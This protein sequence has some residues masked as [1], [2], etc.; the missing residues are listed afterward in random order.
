MRTRSFVLFLFFVLTSV[1]AFAQDGGIR[2]S[3]LEK[4]TRQPVMLAYVNVYDGNNKSMQTTVQTDEMG[5]AVV[6]PERYPCTIEVVSLGFEPF[7]Q[8]FHRQPLSGA[9]A[10]ILTKKFGSINEVVV[11]GNT[12]PMR[13]KDALSSYQVISRAQIQAMGAVTLN[14]A[15]KN[16][17]NIQISNDNILGS[18]MQLQGMSG[19]KVKILKDGVPL[20]GREGG[21]INLSQINLNNVERIEI[22][23]GPMSVTY[24]TDAL[25]GV[26]NI[27]TRN[28]NR[29]WGFNVNT[30]YESIGRYNFDVSG[31]YK[32]GNRHQFTLGGGMN[33]FQGW[34]RIYNTVQY[35]QHSLVTDRE[36]LFKPN[37][38][39][40][41]NFAYNY[42]APSGF[43]MQLASDYIGEKVTNKLSPASGDYNP[44][45]IRAIDE[46]YRTTR[47]M[48]RLALN[49]RLGKKGTWQSQNGYNIYYRTRTTLDVDMTDFSDSLSARPGSQDT[50]RFDDITSR[51]SYTNKIDRVTYTVG[52]DV[53]L[54][55]ANSG[56]IPGGDKQIQDY[57]L[58]TNVSAPFFKNKVTVQG[59]LRASHN[60]AYKAPLTPS[61][62][63]LYSPLK[64][65]QV[66]GSYAKGFRAPSLKEL[67]LSFVDLNHNIIG[68]PDLKSETSDHLQASVSYQLYEKKSNYLQLMFT[69]FYNDV[70][71]GIMLVPVYPDDPTSI[72]Y[73]Y[74]NLFR[75]RNAIATI[76]ADGQFEHLFFQ[77]AYS[78][79]YTQKEEGAYDNFTTGEASF[80][81]QY[82][83]KKQGLN[84][85]FINKYTESRPRIVPGID[86]VPRFEGQQAGFNMMDITAEK[87]LFKKHLQLIA[88]VKNMLNVT[89]VAVTGGSS[90]GGAHGISSGPGGFLPRS[91]FTS[92]RWTID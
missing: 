35:N 64:N 90:G 52:Y 75:Q 85:N 28:D 5:I 74:G 59:G 88:G 38:Q 87:S 55:Y 48:N 8:T 60:T 32:Y 7:T 46:Y 54:S 33:Y 70:K 6:N 53:N 2:V 17:V 58:Y 26:V 78:R 19:N 1:A 57:A 81:I 83:F 68:N 51:S 13:S 72:E 15:L 76:Q 86:G 18:N 49:G 92:M 27:I 66:R 37:L 62:N 14:E 16:Q 47:S 80:L 23:Q 84:L 29:N 43:R 12:Q 69:G 9:L 11:T 50:S 4:D 82:S 91:F 34:Q 73:V 79:N 77:V 40:I 63:L 3:V 44:Y 20:N 45:Y 31:T 36:L 71:N 65:L 42:S 39:R 61:F 25:G 22:V 67:Y 10:V 30:Y 41:G 21:N 24:G 56:K 89:Q